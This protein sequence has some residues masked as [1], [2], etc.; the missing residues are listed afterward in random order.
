MFFDSYPE[1]FFR[2]TYGDAPS[3]NCSL[4]QARLLY[5]HQSL[6]LCIIVHSTGMYR[7][8]RQLLVYTSCWTYKRM[9]RT[10]LDWP[11]SPQSD[12]S[13]C[14]NNRFPPSP[15]LS[16]GKPASR[17]KVVSLSLMCCRPTPHLRKSP[18]LGLLM[19]VS[20]SVAFPA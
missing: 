13:A 1:T 4:E 9:H 17:R 10:I 12:C 19:P 8:T 6:L 15:L 5:A 16:S 11:S 2:I 3:C 7:H 14:R 18:K 20:D